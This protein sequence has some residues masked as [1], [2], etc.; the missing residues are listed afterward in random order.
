MPTLDFLV[1]AFACDNPPGLFTMA[2]K[3]IVTQR[4]LLVSRAMRQKRQAPFCTS[5][6]RQ[7]IFDL[8][9]QTSGAEHECQPPHR[10][11]ARVPSA[12]GYRVSVYKPIQVST[13]EHSRQV[14]CVDP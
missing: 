2:A 3:T 1:L 9:L 13:R 14:Q 7:A 5:V 11:T 8:L 6:G 10:A 4:F 12:F